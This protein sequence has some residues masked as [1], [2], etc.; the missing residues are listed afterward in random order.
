[1]SALSIT[2]RC[3][4]G[5]QGSEVVEFE[6]TVPALE[7]GT[8]EK[9]GKGFRIDGERVYVEFSF[10]PYLIPELSDGEVPA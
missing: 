2:F 5:E 4:R 9:V 6:E 3:L 10:S 7:F 1:M 8:V